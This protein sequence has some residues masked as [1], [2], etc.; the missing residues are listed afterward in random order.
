MRGIVCAMY[1]R[2]CMHVVYGSCYGRL[3]PKRL[4]PRASPYLVSRYRLR[5]S[6][7]FHCK[8]SALSQPFSADD[9]KFEQPR[10]YAEYEWNVRVAEHRVQEW[11]CRVFPLSVQV[12]VRTFLEPYMADHLR[13]MY[14]QIHHPPLWDIIGD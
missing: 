2:L 12:L 13:N 9:L 7:C 10:T 5:P 3:A 11:F 4:R 1:L 6:V 14:T 8:M